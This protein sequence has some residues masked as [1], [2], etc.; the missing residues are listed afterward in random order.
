MEGTAG[1]VVSVNLAVPRDNP[2][3]TGGLSTGIDKRSVD[4]PVEVR[5]P[6]PK[7]GG[8]G[9]GL[10]GDWIGDSRHHGGDDQAVYAYAREDLDRWQDLL[11]RPLAP[12]SFG[13]NLT[14]SGVDVNGALVGERWRIGD[15]LE[16]QVTDPRVPCGTFRGWIG[17]QGWLR[18]FTVAE[19]P[20]T[21]L[22]VTVPGDVRPGD[23]LVVV[24]RPDHGVTVADLFRALMG[25][26]DDP[27][28]LLVAG[29]SLTVEARES[30]QAGTSFDD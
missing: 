20:G 14:T 18:T 4:G 15:T 23:P 5:A 22:R 6:G 24:H 27:Q 1:R 16:L 10:V 21:Y 30:L 25:R 9:S 13:E 19:I 26:A 3:K 7:Q 12:G 8:L 11:G 28:A 2:F 17:E 29:D